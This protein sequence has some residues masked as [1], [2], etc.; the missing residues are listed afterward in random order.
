MIREGTIDSKADHGS[1]DVTSQTYTDRHEST[2]W[3]PHWR[4]GQGYSRALQVV[5]YL[6]LSFQNSF[7]PLSPPLSM[8]IVL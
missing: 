5:R 3:E 4:G 6:A 2:I 7:S 1:T 8:L